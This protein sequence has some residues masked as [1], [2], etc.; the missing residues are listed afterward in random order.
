MKCI[1]K[2]S[3][4]FLFILTFLVGFLFGKWYQGAEIIIVLG[5]F[6]VLFLLYLLYK[7]MISTNKRFES[8]LMLIFLIIGIVFI[9]IGVQID[10]KVYFYTLSTIS[11]TLAALIGI[12][13]IFIIFKLETLT[14][15]KKDY[16]LRLV[17]FSTSELIQSGFNNHY[18]KRYP[19]LLSWIQ[20]RSEDLTINDVILSELSSDLEEIELDELDEGA[21]KRFFIILKDLKDNIEKI[22]KYISEIP[23]LFYYGLF[24]GFVAIIFS[25][26]LLSFGSISVPNEFSS[27]FPY[28]RTIKM[29]AFFVIICFALLSIYHI[30]KVLKDLTKSE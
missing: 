18:Q 12:V 7:M 26:I 24:L 5:I 17:N 19:R 13:G 28:L 6:S 10:N 21:F 3:L 14:N 9:N 11:Q 23:R 29:I 15:Q 30:G 20:Q 25:I 2:P 27:F 4:W 1:K 8:F 22:D 16:K